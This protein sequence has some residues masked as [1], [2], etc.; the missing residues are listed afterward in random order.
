ML[1]LYLLINNTVFYFSLNNIALKENIHRE[2]KDYDKGTDRVS[3]DYDKCIQ[4]VYYT[5]TEKSERDEEKEKEKTIDAVIDYYNQ[6]T[7]RNLNKKTESHRQNI[8]ARLN[9]KY[10][11]ADLVLVIDWKYDQWW[12]DPKT[13]TWINIKS[14]N[15]IIKLGQ[16]LQSF[17]DSDNWIDEVKKIFEDSLKDHEKALKREKKPEFKF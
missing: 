3:I 1:E 8:R 7:G 10:S 4:R 11:F 16:H 17:G 13:R 2:S 9:E 14:S 12:E 5:L 15:I 6:K